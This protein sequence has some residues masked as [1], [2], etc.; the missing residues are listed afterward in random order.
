MID[1]KRTGT[2]KKL[3]DQIVMDANKNNKKTPPNQTKR[4]SKKTK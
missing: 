2:G 1:L 3:I 4:V